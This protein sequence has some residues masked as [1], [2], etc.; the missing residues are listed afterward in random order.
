MSPSQIHSDFSSKSLLLNG[1]KIA[2][3]AERKR[4]EIAK[5]LHGYGA[6]VSLVPAIETI[7]LTQD[8]ELL[9]NS[10]L[11]IDKEIDFAIISTGVGFKNWIY[12]LQ[13]W[14]LK[15]S[16]IGKL[17]KAVVIPRGPKSRSS[18]R[19]LGI[20]ESWMPESESF[21]EIL[22]YF[23]SLDLEN[24]KILVQLHGNN[25][26][27]FI[28]VLKDKGA[29]VIPV[30]IYRWSLP[31]YLT[32]LENLVQDIV[33]KKI[34]SV[35][36]TSAP[37][38]DNLLK[39]A[40]MGKKRSLVLESFKD[41]V[42]PCC[43]GTVTSSTLISEGIVPLMPPKARLGIFIKYIAFNLVDFKSNRLSIAGSDILEIINN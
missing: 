35:V 30:R 18:L 16:L 14:G 2:I 6:E 17:S 5:L 24:K 38:V 9:Q 22:D 42:V 33:D 3:T 32:D 36:F 37:A 28:K 8:K 29:Q 40:D 19:S 41:Y 43:V 15:E 11:C 31:K 34:D 39:V 12:T 1:Y 27:D 10:R 23:S 25:E 21:E 4:Y 7:S 26:Y 20:K 13:Q